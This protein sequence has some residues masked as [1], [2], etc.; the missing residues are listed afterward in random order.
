MPRSAKSEQTVVLLGN[1]NPQHLHHGETNRRKADHLDQSVTRV[2]LWPGIDDP[3]MVEIALSTDNERDLVN[4]ARA[5]ADEHRRYAI[6]VH[7]VEEILKV[8]SAGVKP[9][10]VSSN[11]PDLQ[12]VLAGY[13]GCSEGEPV[14]LVTNGG[15]DAFHQQHLS[16][17]AQPAAC[18]YIALT[19]NNGAG[20]L[21]ADT[22]LTGELTTN[23][24]GRAQATFAHTGGTNTSTLTK[25]FTYT[26]STSQGI[27]SMATFNAVSAGTMGEEDALSSTV[28][29]ATS[30]DTA[31]ITYTFT[32]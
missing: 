7:E 26:G 19:A 13:F 28:T 2:E 1:P 29:V 4:R 20:F 11:D 6:A 9:D 3:D 15:R 14:A 18:N 21:A 8:H 30:G 10:W 25:T 27:A 5:L 16:T 12:H 22:T 32:A 24:L 17:S 31:T 23:G